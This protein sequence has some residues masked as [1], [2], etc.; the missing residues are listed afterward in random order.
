MLSEKHPYFEH[1]E[2][3]FW[4]AVDNGR[5]VARI[6]A[7][8][9]QL[10]TPN[11]Q[12]KIGFFGMFE[13][14]NDTALVRELFVQ[15]EAWLKSKGCVSARGPFSLSINQESGLLVK[16]FDTPA[17]FMMGHAQPYY[18]DLLEACGYQKAKDL[19]AWFDETDFVHPP[20]MRRVIDRYA[21]RI[22]L[23]DLNTK[24]VDQELKLILSLFNEAWANNWG[25]IPFTEHEFMHMGKEMLQIVPANYF[26]IAE[27]D[28]EPAGFIVML[29][30]LN[31]IT[32]DLNGKLLPMGIFKLLWRMRFNPPRSVRVP[33]MGVKQ[34]YQNQMIGS[35]LAFLLIGNIKKTALE[36]GIRT[37]EM[38]WVL[39][40]NMRL[41]KILA[42]LGGEQYK[43]YRIFEK[44][45]L[46]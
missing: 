1:A 24:Q 14:I 36:K 30:N 22:C 6:S 31:E 21:D 29:P 11:E 9:D 39:E 33:L 15:A 32:R 25:F 17:F 42:S 34:K 23:R 3:K 28:N 46:T 16:G 5:P 45:L 19:F 20:A 26:A 41:N 35:A 37:H 2:A 13:S 44:V 7:Q 10:A 4:V 38:S 43:T 12:G 40:D 18:K 8:I 27:I